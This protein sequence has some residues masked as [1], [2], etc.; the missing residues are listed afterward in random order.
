MSLPK[1]IDNERKQ[2]GETLKELSM[3]NEYLSIATGYWDLPGTQIIFDAIKDYKSVRLLIGQ[4]PLMPRYKKELKLEAPEQDFPDKD[5]SFDLA[6]LPQDEGYRKLVTDMKALIADGRLEVRIYRKSF[7]HAKC[8]IFGNYESESAVGIIGSSNFTRAG[9]TSNTELNALEDDYRIVKSTP[10]A[11]TDDYGHLSWFDSVWNDN[12]IEQWDGR[13]SQLLGDSPIGDLTFSPYDMYIKT[14]WELYQDEIVDD[15]EISGDTVEILYSFQ[16]RNAQL[17]LK[18]LNK[19]GLAM[20]ADSVGLGKTITA[21]AVLKHYIEEKQCKRIYIIA[22]ASLCAQWKQDLIDKYKLFTGFEVIS[23]QDTNAI[24]KARSIDKYAPV[25]MFIIDE[26]HNLRN[27]ASKRHQE[28]LEWFSDNPDSKVLLMTATPINNSLTDFVNQIQL[29]AKGSL[30]SFPVVYPTSKKNEV[31]DFFEAVKRLSSEMAKAENKGEKPDFNKVNR[32]MRQ[33]L[34]HFLVRT[35]RKG[36]EKEFGGLLSDDG[37]MRRFPV[38]EV[39]P[40]P[41]NFSDELGS[42]IN[43]VINNNLEVFLGKDPRTLDVDSLLEQTQRTKHPLDVISGIATTNADYTENVFVNVF[44]VMLLLGFSPYRSETYQHRFYGKTPEEI[45][46]FKLPPDESFALQSQMSV[47][48][49]LRVTFLKRLESSPYALRRSLENYQKKLGYFA[50]KLA[51]GY[52]IKFKDM[53]AI[54]FEFGDDLE[55]VIDHNSG[56]ETDDQIALTPADTNK[57]NI[58]T[59]KTDIQKDQRILDVIIEICRT[60]EDNDDK[61]EAFSGLLSKIISEQ[62]AGKKVLVFSYYADTIKYLSEKLPSLI[63]APNFGQKS[64]FISGESKSQ[65]EDIVRRFSPM[66]KTGEQLNEDQQIDYL[67]ATDVLSEGQNL[68]DCGTLINFDLHWNPV[69]MIQR[70]GRINRLGSAYEQVYVFNMHPETNLE[71]Y[72]KL[73]HRLEQKIDRIKYTV[74]TDQSVLGEAENPIEYI[75]EIEESEKQEN[76]VLNLYDEA[77]ATDTFSELDDDDDFLSI[78]EYVLDLRKFLSDATAEEKTRVQNIP[79]GKWGYLPESAKKDINSP[80]VLSLTRSKGTTTETGVDFETHI[81]VESDAQSGYMVDAVETIEALKHIRTTPDDNERA[82]DRIGYDREQ[83]KKYI[84]ALAKRQAVRKN[85]TFKITP[86]I[87]LVLNEIANV[88]PD[89]SVD[90]SLEQIV[91]KQDDKLMRDLFRKANLDLKSHQQ[92][93]PNTISGF[94]KAVKKLATHVNDEK[95]VSSVEGVLL[96]A[97]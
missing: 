85:S 95:E 18:K 91:T 37:T 78:D 51:Q 19:Y 38:S 16:R 44:Q 15:E 25:D 9:L 68:Q 23:M 57:Y 59:L 90:A 41:Y 96:Y 97:K 50:E 71:S 84:L 48:N 7:L 43:N 67:F 64:A 4:E 79:V 76:T 27:D 53:Q 82:L 66:S 61:L 32:I 60:L 39:V 54:Q 5:I 86:S 62:K 94:E 63:S 24:Q 73:V 42:S 92:L 30:E 89:V 29:A 36:I 74:G 11:E 10:K 47:H 45:K 2:M 35:T 87:K 17:L 49:M 80:T 6:T 75:D 69:R 21:G 83:A 55:L 40:S 20:L 13:F 34:R 56:V 12:Q 65:I 22:P 88:L 3:T 58:E 8:Y 70:N 77:K 31:I 52:I 14:L 72:L 1:I 46:Q 93:L 28:L 81:F 33:G 26:A